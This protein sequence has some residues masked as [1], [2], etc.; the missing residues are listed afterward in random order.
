MAT[1]SIRRGSA[2]PGEHQIQGRALLGRAES[3]EI[4]LDDPAASR[5]HALIYAQDGAYFIRD[6]ESRNGTQVN[7]KAISDCRLES[8]D[9]IAI[10]EV[11]MQFHYRPG[12]DWLDETIG[13]FLFTE[14]HVEREGH[15]VLAARH[16]TSGRRVHLLIAREKR[17]DVIDQ[18]RERIEQVAQFTWPNL[19]RPAEVLMLLDHPALVFE[20]EDIFPAAADPPSR[21]R[22]TP[23]KA[24]DLAIQALE[25]VV[26]ARA[27]PGGELSLALDLLWFE[28]EGASLRIVD[29]ILFSLVSQGVATP[30]ARQDAPRQ[31]EA[32]RLLF[33]LLTGS[34]PAAEAAPA[35]LAEQVRQTLHD[36]IGPTF[37]AVIPTVERLLGVSPEPFPSLEAATDALK[38]LRPQGTSSGDRAA[39]T[40]RRTT[41]RG[42]AKSRGLLTYLFLAA[43]TALLLWAVFLGAQQIG[44]KAYP[45]AQ[46]L[47][48]KISALLSSVRR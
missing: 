31:L 34:L 30:E 32:G 43:G 36:A 47:I 6:L 41:R 2:E 24:I 37:P 45:F 14:V 35:D 8:G 4:R 15:A 17:P 7:G 44:K 38:Q 3:S 13:S 46:S 10:G 5:Q 9:R 25:A 21:P 26:A 23:G 48:E 42:R 39:S 18:L 19:L 22:P 12:R 27:T 40:S 11:Q 28:R 20:E 16:A 33:R 29:P 1:L